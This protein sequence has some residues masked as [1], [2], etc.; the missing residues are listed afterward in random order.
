M[1]DRIFYNTMHQKERSMEFYNNHPTF[2]KDHFV[3]LA[4]LLDY[5]EFCD[6]CAAWS[7]FTF[8]RN[9]IPWGEVSY[10][11]EREVRDALNGR[12]NEI[13]GDKLEVFEMFRA[14]QGHEYYHGDNRYKLFARATEE[15][16]DM[17][18]IKTMVRYIVEVEGKPVDVP[19]VEKIYKMYRQ[20]EHCGL[21]PT[22]RF[23]YDIESDHDFKIMNGLRRANVIS[24]EYFMRFVYEKDFDKAYS[25][26][27]TYDFL[28]SNNDGEK[29]LEY[30][31]DEEK[32]LKTNY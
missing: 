20:G 16:N 7:R 6:M 11:D 14:N 25:L 5:E 3:D 4:Y 29:V 18:V 32:V 15:Y 21:I 27:A 2:S 19:M 12:V 30:F 9:S 28:K 1:K 13:L 24:W 10:D 26:I 8:S 23:D 22:E 17:S 31:E